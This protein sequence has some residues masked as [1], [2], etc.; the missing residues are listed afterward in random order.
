MAY[1]EKS[2]W[3]YGLV[4]VVFYAIYVVTVL[5]Q[6]ATTA[7]TEVDYV[8]PLLW[9]IGGS[10][11]ASIVIHIITSIVS[12]AKNDR[13]D[14]RDREIERFGSHVGNA[15]LVIGGVA[16]MLL[17]IF[18]LGYFWIANVLYLCFFLSALL[19]SITKIIAY[20]RGLPAW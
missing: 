9:T 17:A 10:I 12:G 8:P 4:S 20:R 5:G 15:F 18:Q 16:A 7:I 11:V 1:E 14:Q 2:A 19:S 13:R 3:I 6:A